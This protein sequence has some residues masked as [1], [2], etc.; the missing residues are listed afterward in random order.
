M[1]LDAHASSAAS[2]VRHA[3][4]GVAG[5]CIL[6]AGRRRPPNQCIRT[7]SVRMRGGSGQAGGLCRPTNGRHRR[8]HCKLQSCAVGLCWTG[9]QALPGLLPNWRRGL[10][11]SAR[12]ISI[13]CSTSR[14][15]RSRNDF[16]PRVIWPVQRGAHC[17]REG[18][19]ARPE[20]GCGVADQCAACA[21]SEQWAE[22]IEDCWT[23]TKDAE[24]GLIL[25]TEIYPLLGPEKSAVPIPCEILE[26]RFGAPGFKVHARSISRMRRPIA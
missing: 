6:R 22:A 26:E 17:R 25:V 3:R 11:A 24:R 1:L 4:C 9:E 19:L 14:S 21:R 15:Q 2:G 12:P 18:R 20:R 10:A 7:S 13:G 5:V 16:A 8:L 23:A